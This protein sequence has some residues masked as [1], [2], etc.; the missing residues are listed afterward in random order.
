[1]GYML[2]IPLKTKAISQLSQKKMRWADLQNG[3]AGH[4]SN[5][6]TQT[7]DGTC[8]LSWDK[9]MQNYTLY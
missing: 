2:G 7:K 3:L 1:M 4:S 9:D 8:S 6:Q 5:S